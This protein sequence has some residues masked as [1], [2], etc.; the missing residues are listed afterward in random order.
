MH[1]FLRI[2]INNLQGLRARKV[3]SHYLKSFGVEPDSL[4]GE[5]LFSL[6]ICQV[7]EGVGMSWTESQ[8]R[9]VTILGFLYLALL[10]E[11]IGQVT[12][13][14]WEVWLQLDCTAVCINSKVY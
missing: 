11:C 6:D 13:G 2:Y 9:V 12:V 1:I 14:I 8:G 10:F 4:F 7:V 5:T 3:G